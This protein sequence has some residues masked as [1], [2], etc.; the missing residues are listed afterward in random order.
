MMP[1]TILRTNFFGNGNLPDRKSFS[2]WLICN[3]QNKNVITVFS[4]IIF[5]PISINTLGIIMDHIITNPVEGIFNLG[6]H[7]AMS[8]S[9]FAFELAKMYEFETSNIKIGLSSDILKKVYRPKDMSMDCS[10]FEKAFSLN[11]PNLKEEIRN[12]KRDYCV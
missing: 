2:D 5:N 12:L 3:L 7:G 4:D 1:C 8:K 9:E 6:S 11:L 10:R